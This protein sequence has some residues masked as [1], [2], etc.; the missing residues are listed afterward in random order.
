[1]HLVGYVRSSL[2]ILMHVGSIATPK[3]CWN[4]SSRNVSISLK[5]VPGMHRFSRLK[6]QLIKLK[7]VFRPWK[8]SWECAGGLLYGRKK[9]SDGKRV[10]VVRLW[11]RKSEEG[12]S[13]GRVSESDLHGVRLRVVRASSA[14]LTRAQ[15]PNGQT[16]QRPWSRPTPRKGIFRAFFY[17]NGNRSETVRIM[18]FNT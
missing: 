1:M 2:P 16:A 18:S 3:Y 9:I 17:W 8:R 10:S 4:H 6:K 11:G 5:D 13:N 14:L 12:A 15:R 7:Y